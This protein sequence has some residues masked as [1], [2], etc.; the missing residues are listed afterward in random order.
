MQIRAENHPDDE[1]RIGLLCPALRWKGLCSIESCG[2][3]SS[4]T[5]TL[6]GQRY[7][8]FCKIPVSH[9]VTQ[10]QRAMLARDPAMPLN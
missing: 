10:Y 2:R 9:P 6:N 3:N 5:C 4:G 7:A 1:I 8:L